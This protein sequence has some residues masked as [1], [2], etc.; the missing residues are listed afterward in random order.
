[1]IRTSILSAILMTSSLLNTQAQAGILDLFPKKINIQSEKFRDVYSGLKFNYLD[2]ED[3]L[4]IMRD[5]F[6]TIELQYAL[7][8]L[9]KELIGLNYKEMKSITIAMEESIEDVLLDD[10][11]RQNDD[12]REKITFL[13]ASSNMDFFDRMDLMIAKFKDTH[14]G[15]YTK[16]SRPFIY[17]GVRL[18]RMDGR[19]VVGALEKKFLEMASKLSGT[20][21]SIIKIGD[22]VISIDGVPIEEKVNQLKPYI[23]GSTEEYI[24]AQ[25]VFATMF[26]NNRYEK[27][28]YMRVV[29]KNAGAIKL[30]IFANN[31]VSDTPR[32]D[33]ITYLNKYKIQS[34]TTA[35]GLTFDKT[36]QKWNDSNISFSGYN[37]R[38]LAKNLTA[39]NDYIG[40]SGSAAIRTGYYLNK[41]KAYAVLQIM[42]FSTSTVTKGSEK[43]AFLDALRNFILEVKIN[44][45]PLIL[46]LR[47]N[48][49]GNGS[50]PAQ[51]V[52]MLAKESDVYAPSTTAMRM[53]QYTRGLN[54]GFLV[55]QV[56]AENENDE[57][58]I[59]MLQK[60]IDTALDNRADC[61]PMYTYCAPIKA[62]SIIKGFNN[63][64]VM[65]VT[66]ACISA[67]D[68]TAF[69]IKDSKRAT[70]IGTHS[71]GTGAGFSSS[72]SL[73]TEW[74]DRLSVFSS[75]IPNYLFGKPGNNINTI[76]YGD[77]SVSELCSENKPTM[78]DIEYKSSMIDLKYDNLGWLQKAAEVINLN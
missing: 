25:A 46:D 63:K 17:T 9:K 23:S 16:I 55:Q 58:T 47:V 64:V 48:N 15:V 27:K 30:P 33:V 78:A 8:P 71:N 61:T 60:L 1:M 19:I 53:T 22:E 51:L 38:N 50:Y 5:L 35:I 67:C 4:L 3:R 20:D 54:E 57:I 13:Q 66:A 2:K 65:L 74:G 42:T 76:I 12:A 29:F 32:L 7:L 41:G 31:S 49:G 18:Y 37:T 70:I 45:L 72:G 14:F 73:N 11:D 40:E 6:K 44:E 34:D 75:T 28:N 21:L 10:K 59:D 39:T 52:S 56:V 26:R 62:D 68:K 69:L 77:D 43:L 36:T 24:D